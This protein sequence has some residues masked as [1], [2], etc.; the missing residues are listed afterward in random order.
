MLTRTTNTT[1][2]TI[3]VVMV[4]IG[5]IAIVSTANLVI[6]YPY[7]YYQLVRLLMLLA[8]MLGH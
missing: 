3:T 5:S 8:L 6:S 4:T 7:D 1:D 2:F